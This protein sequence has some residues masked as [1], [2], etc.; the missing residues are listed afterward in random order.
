MNTITFTNENKTIQAENGENLL[1]LMRR[2]GFEPD[3]PCGGNGKCGKCKVTLG[4]GSTVLACQTKI[5]GDLTITDIHGTPQDARILMDASLPAG[6]KTA[7]AP[8]DGK[9]AEAQERVPVSGPMLREK[10][11]MEIW[12]TTLSL[13]AETLEDIKKAPERSVVASRV[14]LA[15]LSGAN[16]YLF[17]LVIENFPCITFIYIIIIVY[18]QSPV[19]L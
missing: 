15:R 4:D 8:R 14:K 1:I 7:A 16:R 9:T 2:A 17:V 11:V 3:A 19:K 13:S 5:E 12:S 18:V 10:K 6:K